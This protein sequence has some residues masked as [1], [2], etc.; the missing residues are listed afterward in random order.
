MKIDREQENRRLLKKKLCVTNNLLE[1]IIFS[2][3]VFWRGHYVN[4][5]DTSKNKISETR[6]KED[7][8][9][10]LITLETFV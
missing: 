4:V 9:D 7:L 3:G 6:K 2:S 8:I 10:H 1:K 5:D